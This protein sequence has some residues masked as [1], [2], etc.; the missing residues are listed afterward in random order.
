[1]SDSTP[2]HKRNLKAMFN[3]KGIAIVGA[4]S[5]KDKPGNQ[6]VRFAKSMD[7]NGQ[8]YPIN[9]TQETIEGLKCYKNIM[10]IPGR[11]DLIVLVVGADECIAVAREIARQKGR[12]G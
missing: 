2:M 9:P 3:A 7:F 12:K 8:I 4:S 5:K 6:I 11:V 1:M 10:D